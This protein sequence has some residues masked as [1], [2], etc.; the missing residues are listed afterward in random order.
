MLPSV[1]YFKSSTIYYIT[2]TLL[3]HQLF[4]KIFKCNSE[5]LHLTTI[6]LITSI[7]INFRSMRWIRSWKDEITHIFIIPIESSTLRKLATSFAAKERVEGLHWR[8]ILVAWNT[9]KNWRY[10]NETI[11]FNHFVNTAI[12]CFWNYQNFNR[13]WNAIFLV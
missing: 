3:R 5:V 2:N 1:I 13:L 6:I 9:H 11:S 8:R 10:Q 4:R 12:I 7:Y